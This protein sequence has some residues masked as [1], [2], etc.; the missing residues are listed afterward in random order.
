MVKK[1]EAENGRIEMAFGEVAAL[2]E[3]YAARFAAE[4]VRRG[5]VVLLMLGNRIEW[6]CSMLACFRQGYVALPC[7]EQLRAKDLAQRAAVVSPA[8]VIADRRNEAVVREAGLTPIEPPMDLG[9]SRW[10]NPWVVPAVEELDAEDPCLITF[11]SGTS[12]EPKAA[13]HG[14][15]YLPGQNLQAEHWLGPRRGELVWC[16][17]ASGWSKSARNAFI[18]PWLRGAAALLHDG[19]FDPEERLE[20]CAREH[21][22]VLCMAPTEYRVTAKRVGLGPLPSV[23]SM[24][25]AGEALDPELR[26]SALS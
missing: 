10:S 25:A 5:D 24:V 11:T 21:V 16:T 8:L 22:D 15:R 3:V 9:I 20:I 19:R 17:A 1:L 7:N 23:R 6:V 14:Q 12:G 4:G 2:A 13:I 18:A 26:E